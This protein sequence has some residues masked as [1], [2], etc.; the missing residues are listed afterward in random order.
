MKFNKITAIRT[1]LIIMSI[2]GFIGVL[3]GVASIP[4][5]S[6]IQILMLT[7]TVLAMLMLSFAWNP[8]KTRLNGLTKLLKKVRENRTPDMLHYGLEDVMVKLNTGDQLKE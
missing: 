4:Q 8:H 3:A 5:V 6:G 2:G 1:T 7:L